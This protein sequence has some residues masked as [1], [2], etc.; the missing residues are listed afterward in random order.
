MTSARFVFFNMV[1]TTTT[2][3]SSTA[4][5]K[6]ALLATCSLIR[7]RTLYLDCGQLFKVAGQQKHTLVTDADMEEDCHAARSKME[8]RLLGAFMVEQVKKKY[9]KMKSVGGMRVILTEVAGKGGGNHGISQAFVY[10]CGFAEVGG[11]ELVLLQNV[12]RSM[13]NNVADLFNHLYK[14]HNEGH[15][16]DHGHT[17][18]GGNGIAYFVM[19]PDKIEASL[20]KAS[21]MLEPT[22]LY[23]LVGYDLLL[24]VPV[25]SRSE[26]LDQATREEVLVLATGLGVNG[27]KPLNKEGARSLEVCAW[28]HKMTKDTGARLAKCGGC[29]K[30]YYCSPEHQK[31]DWKRHKVL[32]RRSKEESYSIAM[33][34]FMG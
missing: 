22:R 23:G 34:P 10:T 29:K 13:T 24:I 28:C 9:R 6:E 26:D 15:P 30:E 31:L 20:L 5:L 16:L 17:I 8:V 19:A 14:E 25:G 33:K 21:K 3:G 12:H 2:P 7:L 32:C 4:T 11:K 1:T 18:A 27:F